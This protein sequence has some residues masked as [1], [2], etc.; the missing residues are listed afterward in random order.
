MFISKV[1][2]GFVIESETLIFA[3][4]WTQVSIFSDSLA[5][6]LIDSLKHEAITKDDTIKEICP[7]Q[8]KNFEEANKA[9]KEKH[10][11]KSNL[12]KKERTSYS[13]NNKILLISLFAMTVIGS[14]YYM[15]D[16]KPE[17]IDANWFVLRA[18]WYFGIAFSIYFVIKSTRLGSMTTGMIGWVAGLLQN[19]WWL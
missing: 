13:L 6:P 9:A 5:R 15:L 1:S 12:T 17:V 2:N 16:S 18:L 19:L 4:K 14:T 10:L 7:L 3:A 8:L 11:Q